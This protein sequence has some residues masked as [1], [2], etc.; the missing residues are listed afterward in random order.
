MLGID[1]SVVLAQDDYATLTRN[2]R[3]ERRPL[4][5]GIDGLVWKADPFPVATQAPDAN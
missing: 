2:V 4:S 5:G 3:P 1:L